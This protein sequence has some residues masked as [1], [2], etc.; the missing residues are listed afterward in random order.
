MQNWY[1]FKIC[2]EV[3]YGWSSRK[4]AKKIV[5]VPSEYEVTQIFENRTECLTAV[6]GQFF[7]DSI[8]WPT[9]DVCIGQNGKINP[10]RDFL[11]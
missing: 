6:C 5:E 4:K 2:L 1:L 7:P 9:R 11:W 10:L 3:F 8:Y